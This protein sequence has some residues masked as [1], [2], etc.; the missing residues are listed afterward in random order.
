MSVCVYAYVFA[1]NVG[2][3]FW[4]YRIGCIMLYLT[5]RQ[6]KKCTRIANDLQFCNGENNDKNEKFP[7]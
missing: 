1:P 6:K 3:S 4:V 2:T 7:I 5:Y